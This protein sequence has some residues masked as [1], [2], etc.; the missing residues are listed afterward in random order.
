MK[1]FLMALAVL[2]LACAPA[3]AGPNAGG[4]LVVQDTGLAYTVD[5]TSYP[6]TAPDPACEG[7][8]D[9]Q[10]PVEFTLAGWVWK[11]YAA[12]PATATPR[13]KALAVG[14]QF[15]ADVF[16]LAGGLPDPV[17]DFD[18]PQGGWPT[19]SG[20][21]DGISFGVAKTAY[22]AE[23]YWFGG[24]GYDGG[25]FATAP[26]PSQPMLF[27]DDSVPPVE[28]AIVGLSSI[29][30][31]SGIGVVVCPTVPH[32]GACCF[33]DGTCQMLFADACVAAGGTVYQGACDP[34]PCPPPPPTAA[35]CIGESCSIVTESLCV[36][37]GGTWYP[38]ITCDPNPCIIPVQETTW[39]QIKANY[40]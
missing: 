36:G 23:I 1:K 3:L 5:S 24:Y 35:C 30:F 22:M 28:D 39:G 27:V 17:A 25:V 31:G 18:I 40:R 19:T 21:G 11:I 8:I 2:A 6:S 4:T 12:F 34:N 16:V 29:G 10:I 38:G 13:L 33:T 32:E 37:A 7:T 14:E 26:H 20:G 9:A 15:G